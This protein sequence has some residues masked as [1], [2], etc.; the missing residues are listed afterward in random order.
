MTTNTATT[1]TPTGTRSVDVD[2]FIDTMTERDFDRIW[3]AAQDKFGLTGTIFCR[4]DLDEDITD[5]QWD[6]IRFNKGWKN[7]GEVGSFAIF[8]AL[9]HV[10][11]NALSDLP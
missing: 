5:D 6:T 10:V 9:D 1:D 3:F 8:L 2:A 7:L 4:D 11:D